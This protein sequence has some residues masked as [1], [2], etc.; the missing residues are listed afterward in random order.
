M[1]R[2]QTTLAALFLPALVAGGFAACSASSASIASDDGGTDG[3]AATT[4]SGS[5]DDS[6]VVVDEDSGS[7]GDGSKPGD[8]GTK[9]SGDAKV[10]DSSIVPDAAKDCGTA[11]TLHPTPSA[12]VFCPFQ[13]ND[14]SVSCPT[15][16]GEHC[17]IYPKAANKPAT[18]NT[19]IQ[20]CDSEIDAGGSD[21]E[22]DEPADCIGGQVCCMDG[23]ALKD[24]ACYYF[25]SLVRTTKC[26]AACNT[27]E[28]TVCS[29]QA[30]CA[31]GTCT[32]MDTKGKELGVCLP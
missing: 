21:F 24:P 27:G 5:E 26:R 16:P 3:T 28:L 23:K 2:L 11:P 30:Q 12:G 4:D 19:L 15:T 25:G 10:T 1:P 31:T 32:P 7:T 20:G 18:C 17:C 29:A 13:A 14:A 8:G 22:C 9:D 6:S